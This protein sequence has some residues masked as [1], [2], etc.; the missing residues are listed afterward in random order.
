MTAKQ[1]AQTSQRIDRWLWCARI[2]KT[3]TLAAKFVE[4]GQVR[5]TRTEATIRAEKPSFMVRPADVLVF[6]YADRLRIL[7]V[8]D[9]A[10]RR[11]PASKA[12]LLYDDQSPPP[13][14]KEERKP[15][16]FS[17]EKGAGRP[18]KKDRRRIT[19][20]KTSNQSG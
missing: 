13:L 2:F 1:E 3:R 8:K 12:Q 15:S 6:T 16:P 17:R 18:T 20:L 10:Q 11:G 14:P 19:A 5:V 4:G 9:L 7:A